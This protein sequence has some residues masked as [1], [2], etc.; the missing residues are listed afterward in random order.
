MA[1]SKFLYGILHY[2]ISSNQIIIKSVHQ[3]QFYFNHASHLNEYLLEAVIQSNETVG[4][5]C[6]RVKG[7]RKIYAI[8]I[9]RK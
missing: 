1:L 6:I 2:L 4:N 7:H 5:K 8:D 9:I 3:K